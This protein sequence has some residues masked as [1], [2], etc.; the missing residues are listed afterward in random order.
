MYEI[1]NWKYV[2]LHNMDLKKIIVVKNNYDDFLFN[3]LNQNKIK[4]SQDKDLN[5]LFK[6]LYG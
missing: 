6:Q 5:I 3:K 2:T 4:F 1:W